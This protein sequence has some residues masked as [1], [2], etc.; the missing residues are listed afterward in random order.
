MTDCEQVKTRELPSK[1]ESGR[2]VECV[3]VVDDPLTAGWRIRRDRLRSERLRASATPGESR[4]VR[5]GASDPIDIEGLAE[6]GAVLSELLVQWHRWQIGFTPVSTCGAD[7][8]FRNAKSGKGWDTTG[9]VIHDELNASTMEAIDF[10]VGELPEVERTQPYRS[11]IYT[12][13]KN[14]HAGSNVWTSARLPVDP[15][16]RSVI[17]MEARNMLTRRLIAAGVM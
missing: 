7:P 11:A 13:A 16:E 9:Q 5:T 8:M 17:Y 14:L 6:C 15:M 4:Y 12:I 3:V 1:I 10:H 2:P